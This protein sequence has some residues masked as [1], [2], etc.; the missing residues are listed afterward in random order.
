MGNVVL[1]LL[2]S[3]SAQ[4]CFTNAGSDTGVMLLCEVALGDMAEMKQADYYAAKSRGTLCSYKNRFQLAQ[5][6]YVLVP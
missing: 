4:Y 3:K 5:Y 2:Q 1:F 6:M